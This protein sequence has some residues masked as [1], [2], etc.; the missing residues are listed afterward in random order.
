MRAIVFIIG[1]VSPLRVLGARAL[2]ISGE[3]L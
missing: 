3:V 2:S 1:D